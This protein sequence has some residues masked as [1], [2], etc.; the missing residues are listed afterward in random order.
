MQK[1]EIRLLQYLMG[2]RRTIFQLSFFSTKYFSAFDRSFHSNRY[3][4]VNR[5]SLHPSSPI[6]LDLLTSNSISIKGFS[7]TAC[8]KEKGAQ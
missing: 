3:E 5:D 1:P 2:S 4:N 6:A 7:D 8:R